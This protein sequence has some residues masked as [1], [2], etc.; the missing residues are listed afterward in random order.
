MIVFDFYLSIYIEKVKN[1]AIK[2]NV[3]NSL[4]DPFKKSHH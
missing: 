1:V 2:F 3:F 4:I